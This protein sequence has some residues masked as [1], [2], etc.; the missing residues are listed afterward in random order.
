MPVY[1]T[2][3]QCSLSALD[4]LAREKSKIEQDIQYHT[5]QIMALAKQINEHGTSCELAS[6]SLK[7]IDAAIARLSTSKG[8]VEVET[9]IGGIGTFKEAFEVEA[10]YVDGKRIAGVGQ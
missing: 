9:N 2:S 10:L 1:P 6:K 3:E 4:V 5:D 7:N 8:K